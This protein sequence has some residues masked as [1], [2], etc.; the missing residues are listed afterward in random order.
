MSKATRYWLSWYEIS[1]DHRPLTFPPGEAILGWW[2]SGYD[3]NASIL[4]AVVEAKSED[5]A[6]EAVAKDW[7]GPT[8]KRF[9]E[10]KDADW[11]P[12]DRFPPSEWMVDRFAK[13]KS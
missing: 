10:A 1:E 6:W 8:R 3:D 13:G 4:C 11:K 5:A 9:C 12:G 7:P 2:C